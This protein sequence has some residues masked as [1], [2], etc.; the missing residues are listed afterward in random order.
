MRLAGWQRTRCAHSA[1]PPLFVARPLAI[2][3]CHSVWQRNR[4]PHKSEASI[5][6]RATAK[7]KIVYKATQ[8]AAAETRAASC[9]LALS[10]LLSLFPSLSGTVFMTRQ[11]QLQLEIK[12]N[13]NESK[14]K[15][16]ASKRECLLPSLPKA[17]SLSLSLEL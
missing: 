15:V 14:R 1:P 7:F 9:A 2:A 10:R 6:F 16:S 8:D 5:N 11:Q 13:F 3:M 17:P 12:M 4:K